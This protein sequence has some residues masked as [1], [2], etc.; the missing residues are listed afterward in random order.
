MNKKLAG[1]FAFMIVALALFTNVKP[2]Y[3]ME[4]LAVD[5]LV[6]V[7]EAESLS[8]AVSEADVS[9]DN[10]AYTD[11]DGDDIS[12]DETE[13]DRNTD[14]EGGINVVLS[15]LSNALPNVLFKIEWSVVGTD[16]LIDDSE[17]VTVLYGTSKDALTVLG[18]AS[19]AE[20]G[21]S[22]N[23]RLF[24]EGK[25]YLQIEGRSTDG[26]EWSSNIVTVTVKETATKGI[27]NLSASKTKVTLSG[28][29]SVEVQLTWEVVGDNKIK[30]G[31]QVQLIF[32]GNLLGSKWDSG[33]NGGSH[34]VSISKTGTYLLILRGTYVDP[35][36]GEDAE[37]VSNT[38]TIVAIEPY[39]VR[40]NTTDFPEYC[41]QG[42]YSFKFTAKA[43]DGS[44]NIV[45]KPDSD[46]EKYVKEIKQGSTDSEGNTTFVIRF[47]NDK[48]E[49]GNK[50][51]D[52]KFTC[53]VD[54]VEATIDSDAAATKS[55][56]L[57]STPK[58]SFNKKNYSIDYEMAA[59]VNTGETSGKESD[60]SSSTATIVKEVTK[61]YIKIGVDSALVTTATKSGAS[62]TLDE[63]TLKKLLDDFTSEEKL[64][65]YSHDLTVRMYPANS[66]VYNRNVYTEVTEKVYRVLIKY[67]EGTSSENA[68]GD[69]KEIVLF[70]FEGQKIKLSD[71]GVTGK[72]SSLSNGVEDVAA[73]GVIT[74]GSTAGENTYTGILVNS[75]DAVKVKSVSLSKKNMSLEVG[76]SEALT[77][78][79]L[80]DNATN[81]TLKWTSSNEKVATVDS[82]GRVTAVAAG[83]ATIKAASTD[84]SNKSASCTVEVT[85]K[86]IHVSFDIG[87]AEIN[88]PKAI[89]VV[90]NKP[91]GY[92]PVLSSRTGWKHLGW[93]T[94]KTGGTLV[95]KA[96]IVT[97]ALDHTLYAH[98]EAWDEESQKNGEMNSGKDGS[99][100]TTKK[101]DL[102]G[103]FG[104][105][106]GSA[107]K[108][109]IK[110]K[111]QKKLASVTN[112]GIFSAK[113]S[114]KVTVTV[115]KK[116]NGIET[117]QDV[118][119]DVVVPKGSSLSYGALYY[120]GQTF[121]LNTLIK[122]NGLL[123]PNSWTTTAKSTIATV[124]SKTGILTVGDKDGSATVY[125]V[126]GTDKNARKVKVS[127]KISHKKVDIT[128]DFTPIT[129]KTRYIITDKNEK[130]I[131]S[132]T[133]KG[134]LTAKKSGA[135]TVTLQVK[136]GKKWDDVQKK[137]YNVTNPLTAGF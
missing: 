51:A 63:T 3:A 65:R 41:T 86:K 26:K 100:I 13:A 7:D 93:Y 61:A 17:K 66:S 8:D 14:G 59:K 71:L 116:E 132:V 127:V 12:Y 30:G 78:T 56:T 130:K 92:L 32:N 1:M 136:N 38:V 76:N 11:S 10:D 101:I 43:A 33:A 82:Y 121:D 67:K 5:E 45:W 20:S 68:S 22:V 81:K 83:T 108:F 94:E 23:V 72:W 91:Y 9:Y 124:D 120:T 95:D 134:I 126:Y 69:V 18:K 123:H 31:S 19:T 117:E 15:A 52:I 70:R 85:D 103:E 137:T 115:Q 97:N 46:S 109:V 64:L 88:T 62:S 42:D 4:D 118:T 35:D 87:T 129:G 102:S 73:K 105:V 37:W 60:D 135:V 36:T 16:L 96:T 29:Q 107:V 125:A 75:G 111:A 21:G 112:K 34:K 128:K 50:S 58:S 99:S 104:T 53:E 80:P 84:E 79:V 44:E 54:G 27:V 133:T 47:N 24:T 89:G 119:Y 57:Y 114:G 74:V 39:S 98:W 90:I 40:V 106:T 131:A 55:L 110:D 25:Y 122:D 6:S 2:V 77:A 49:P 28:D 113:K 48:L